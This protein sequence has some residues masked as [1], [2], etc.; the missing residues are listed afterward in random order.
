[1]AKKKNTDNVVKFTEDELKSLEAVRNDYLNIQQ[2]FGRTKVRKILALKQVD[3][4]EQYGVQ[5]E[6]A[7]LQ[8]QE[9]E[10]TLAKT[11]ED[12]YGKGNLNVETGEFTPIS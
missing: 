7:Y 12:K 1:M 5:L 11:L 10:Q 3:E 9:T 8:V 4:I 6:S 2:E